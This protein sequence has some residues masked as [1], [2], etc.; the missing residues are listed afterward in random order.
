MLYMPIKKTFDTCFSTAQ[1]NEPLLADSECEWITGQ[2]FADVRCGSSIKLCE[3]TTITVSAL[4][5]GS[6]W[7]MT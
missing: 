1:T 6:V 5:F 4:C 7:A 2:M 3:F